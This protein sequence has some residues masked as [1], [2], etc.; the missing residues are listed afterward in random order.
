M[1]SSS[2]LTWQGGQRLSKDS[3]ADQRGLD[4]TTSPKIAEKNELEKPVDF[5]SI[6]SAMAGH[7]VLQALVATAELLKCSVREPEAV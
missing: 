3:C 4:S 5:L 6:S 1:G 7:I 2:A